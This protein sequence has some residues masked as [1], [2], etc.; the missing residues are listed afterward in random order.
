M[1]TGINMKYRNF[2]YTTSASCSAIIYIVPLN[3]LIII[4][5]REL[6][7][8]NLPYK[9][10]LLSIIIMSA[11]TAT[12]VSAEDIIKLA[13]IEVIGTTPLHGIGLPADQ[14]ASNVQSATAADIAENQGLDITDFMNKTFGSVTINSAQN[15]PFQPDLQFRGFTASPLVGNS[16]GISVYMDGVRV[17]EPF[18]DAVNFELI[19][20]SAIASMNLMPGSNPIFGL[21]TL[22]GAISIQTKNGF[23]HEGH[24]LEAYG[25]SFGR[26]STTLESG[27]NDGTWGYFITG[28]HT[29]EDGW[30]DES[31]SDI[32]QLFATLS[33]RNE[34]STLDLSLIGVDSDLNGNG[35]SPVELVAMDREAVFTHPDNTQNELRMLTLNGSHWLNDSLLLSAN[36][37][38]RNNDR[39]TFN[40]DGAEL[41]FDGAG[42][43]VEEG[44]TDKLEDINGNFINQ[45]D[46]GGPDGDDLALNNTSSTEQDSY[47]LSVQFTF[48]NE[49]FGKENQLIVGASYDRSD[50]EYVAN[51]EVA[52]F[53]TDRGTNGTG[54]LLAETAVDGD[55]DTENFGLF[56][57]DTISMTDK[58]ALTVAARYNRTEIY[59]SGTS[60]NGEQDLN[61]R[62][63][64]HVFNRI[65]P[66]LGLTYAMSETTGI[67]GSYSE[68][69]RAPTPSELTC[70]DPAHPCALPNS[71][72]SDP[73]L[74]DV[75]A[76][77]FEAGVRGQMGNVDWSFGFFNTRVEDAIFFFPDSD[78]PAGQLNVGIFDNID[79][80]QRSGFEFGLAGKRE[81][82]RWTANY[83]IVD[84][85]YESRFGY[86]DHEGTQQFV[87]KGNAI[88]GIP[89]N[90]I[91][92][93]L[94]YAFTP[95]FS[96]GMNASY[97]SGQYLR[98]D[99]VNEDDKLDGYGVV[100][101]HSR[102][103][104]NKNIEFFAK[105]DN[106]FD[107]E[108]ETFGL[109]GEPDEAP[110]LGSLTNER[111]VGT[112]APRAGWIGIKLSL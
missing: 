103:K 74:E 87:E 29:E 2:S 5:V 6:Q 67:Y 10:S 50:V 75:V 77:T 60:G 78:A 72:L 93:G 42:D 27:G 79:R 36:T 17:N 110:G 30:R 19:P 53:R 47:G 37:Y 112:S 40:G 107:S 111:F 94:D 45:T 89:K 13:D 64:K 32:D 90:N 38:F 4:R 16:Q 63:E 48:L 65:N 106:L 14:I 43:L 56:F 66:S 99:N 76:K 31:P 82:L 7:I 23:T 12:A 88:P 98:G 70:A 20:Q 108:Y 84:A 55:I 58:L 97:H 26:W 1:V 18:G 54:V 71:F 91:K 51:S 62:D 100:N 24:S 86:V 83:S 102:Y 46:L 96:L 81:N 104:L 8:M 61:E 49:L 95:A 44:E 9:R 92:I 15:N 11:V 52:V 34:A 105:V 101:L 22:G 109:Y 39:E 68:S 25:G 59:I 3:R 69:N 57:T 73:P 33:Y 21:N 80:T 35:A 41:D 85:S 28:A